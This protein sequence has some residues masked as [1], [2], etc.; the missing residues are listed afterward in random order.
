MRMSTNETPQQGRSASFKDVHGS[1]VVLGDKNHIKATIHFERF[2]D[3]GEKSDP[4]V[5]EE[6]AKKM[7]EL[8]KEIRALGDEHEV[9]RDVQLTPAAT[10]AKGEAAD[11]AANPGK[12]KKTFI[13]KFKEISEASNK[14]VEVGT[15]LAP[16]I[17]T[18]GKLIGIA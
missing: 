9:L 1:V 15:K 2:K 17:I 16:F 13:E 11:I 6:V 18:I 8:Q 7:D 4:K 14:V 5:W 10:L 12:P 3:F